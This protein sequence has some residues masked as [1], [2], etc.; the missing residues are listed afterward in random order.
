MNQKEQEC[1]VG[2]DIAKSE[3]VV[4]VRPT[5]AIQS[6]PN[7]QEGLTSLVE[8][9]RPLCPVLIL[10]EA[11]GGFSRAALNALAM[12]RVPVVA[13]NPRQIRDFA[14]SVG[15]L[16]KTDA[17]DAQV[18]ARFAEAVR[19]EERPLK[20]L[21][22]QKLEE[23]NTRRRQI[24]E[25]LTAEKNRLSAARGWARKD[26][27]AHI[28]WLEKRLE[29]V[30]RELD[31]FITK[32]P[33]WRRKQTILTSFLGVGPV[34]TSTLLG[35]LPELGTLSGRKISALIGVAPFNR[36][37]GKYRGRRSCWGGRARVRAALYMAALT[38]I[39]HNPVIRVFYQRLREAGKPF[40]VAIVACMRKIL[41]TLNAMLKNNT[42]WNET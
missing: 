7:T 4:A 36:D 8:W 18:I 21:D 31:D 17:I 41:V 30:N 5:G 1:F 10:M 20:D 3:L 26:I 11:T 22:T 24:V 39:R 28:A 38:A 16:A 40:K 15:L 13:V 12:A 27:Q 42:C 19:P 33:L 14:R 37:S 35:G 32:S 23:L 34:V 9:L 6:F 2:I 29:N 25:M